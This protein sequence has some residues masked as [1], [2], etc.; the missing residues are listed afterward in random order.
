[1]AA[2]R[3]FGISRCSLA[4]RKTGGQTVVTTAAHC[5]SCAAAH[6]IQKSRATLSPEEGGDALITEEHKEKQQKQQNLQGDV[7]RE[8]AT[9]P[10]PGTG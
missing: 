1:M 2:N 10:V 6:Q 4:E 3:G 8:T 9:G 7:E 5:L